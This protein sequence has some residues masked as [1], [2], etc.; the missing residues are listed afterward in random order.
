MCFSIVATFIVSFNGNWVK[1]VAIAECYAYL[2]WGGGGV[3]I[4][5]N[6]I[7]INI[8]V[9]LFDRDNSFLIGP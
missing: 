9:L 3:E 5:Y 8:Y 2:I 6:S 7:F 1:C 4:I